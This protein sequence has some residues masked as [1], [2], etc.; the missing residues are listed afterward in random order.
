MGFLYRVLA[1]INRHFV[2][3]VVILVFLLLAIGIPRM[4]WPAAWP[5]TIQA[6][7]YRAG[8]EGVAYHDTTVDNTCNCNG[9]YREDEGVD[10]CTNAPAAG[11]HV[12]H[13]K[14]GEWTTY[15]V[16]FPAAGRYE[17]ALYVACKGRS[18][19][20]EVFIGDKSAGVFTVPDTGAWHN[21]QPVAVLVDA[22]AG[23]Q[24]VKVLQG[25]TFTFDQFTLTPADGITAAGLTPLDYATYYAATGKPFLLSWDDQGADYYEVRLFSVERNVDLETVKTETNKTEITLP[26][27]GHFVA[28]IRACATIENKLQCGDWS[29][30]TD[31]EIA[32]VNG[33]P[34]G[35]WL[36][37]HPAPPGGI[38]VNQQQ[39]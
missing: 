36:Y 34:K 12:G 26:Y 30:T 6:E 25:P 38:D 20:G 4:S 37:G 13:T 24:V 39:E 16:D 14:P 11:C 28:Y 2:L 7:D 22:A 5:L 31:E 9:G 8:G 15:D 23:R 27:A 21:F 33:M 29:K 3:I 18:G 10:V 1:A 17:M 19:A 32:R 35:F